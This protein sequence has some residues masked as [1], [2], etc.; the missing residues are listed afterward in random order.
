MQ[1]IPK[2]LIPKQLIPELYQHS[3]VLCCLCVCVRGE[4]GGGVQPGVGIR[5]R[6]VC[7]RVF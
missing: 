7:D 4:G 5:S 6:L 3:R 1:L 2:Q